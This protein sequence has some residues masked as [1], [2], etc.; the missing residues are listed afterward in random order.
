MGNPRGV[1]RDFDALE[2]RRLTGQKLLASGI[3]QSEVARQ[4][5]VHRQSV[6][7]WAAALSKGGPDALRKAGRAGRLPRLSPK[8]KELI[9]GALL[10]GP[11]AQGYSTCLWTIGRVAA[12]IEAL[13]GVKYHKGHAWKVLRGLGWSSQR[14]VGRALERNEEAIAH[15][16]KKQWPAIKKKR[17]TKTGR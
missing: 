3:H 7:R 10:A 17:S 13:T 12:L 15:W 16:K 1:K 14:P 11:E 8:Q 9:R 6:N 4:L 2:K 5:G